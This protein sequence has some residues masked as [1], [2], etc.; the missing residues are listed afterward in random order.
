MGNRGHFGTMR[1]IST[2][3][4]DATYQRHHRKQATALA[5][6]ETAGER[7]SGSVS[8]REIDRGGGIAFIFRPGGRNQT[9]RP[10]S[11]TDNMTIKRR[12][13][14]FGLKRPG[15]GVAALFLEGDFC[16][17]FGGRGGFKTSLNCNWADEF[18]RSAR[19]LASK[20]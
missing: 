7:R 6:A 9:L 11:S 15:D 5:R 20:T 10:V 18:D 12:T 13:T 19:S 3:P 8:K 17:I 2:V 14:G 4:L 16:R 1:T